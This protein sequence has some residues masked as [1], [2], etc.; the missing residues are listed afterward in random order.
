M[1]NTTNNDMDDM[2]EVDHTNDPWVLTDL[3]TH[4]VELQVTRLLACIM[5]LPL[6]PVGVFNLWHKQ[7]N[8]IK[9]GNITLVLISGADKG[10]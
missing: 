10:N 3:R 2:F 4:Q 7:F 5:G 1:Q 6:W 9:G 8:H